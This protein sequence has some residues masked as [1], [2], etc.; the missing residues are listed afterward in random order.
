MNIYP[1][2][3]IITHSRAVVNS[4]EDCGDGEPVQIDRGSLKSAFTRPGAPE[5]FVAKPFDALYFIDT[6]KLRP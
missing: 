5:V 2:D 6:M 4:R 3:C 1:L